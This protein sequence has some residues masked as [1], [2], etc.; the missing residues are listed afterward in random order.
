MNV[1]SPPRARASLFPRRKSV[2]RR[3]VYPEGRPVATPT[4]VEVPTWFTG[5]R[6]V[7][8]IPTPVSQRC[9]KCAISL[10]TVN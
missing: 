10:I 8:D 1:P 9:R 7:V 5:V 4:V 3:R 6:P 2:A